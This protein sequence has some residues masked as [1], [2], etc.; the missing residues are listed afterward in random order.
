[1]GKAV[2]IRLC[3]PDDSSSIHNPNKD[4]DIGLHKVVLWSLY[5]H[6]VMCS[7]PETPNKVTEQS[8]NQNKQVKWFHMWNKSFSPSLLSTCDFP[9]EEIR[10]PVFVPSVIFSAVN[11]YQNDKESDPESLR[12]RYGYS[13]CLQNYA[14]PKVSKVKLLFGIKGE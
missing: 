9:F 8:L 11:K 12:A 5:V 14:I 13:V 4:G 3:K 1:M 2:T 7:F 6:S 10:W